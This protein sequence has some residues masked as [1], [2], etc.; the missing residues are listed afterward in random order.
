MERTFNIVGMTNTF[1]VKDS[2]NG[3]NCNFTITKMV[4]E[5]HT[6]YGH[7]DGKPI[8]IS[9]SEFEGECSSGWCIASWA[10]I[11]VNEVKEFPPFSYFP[12]KSPM[13]IT[14]D[15]ANDYIDCAAFEYS[16]HGDDEYYPSGYYSINFENFKQT[17][18]YSDKRVV[19]VFCGASGLGKTYLAG[20]LEEVDVYETDSNK[21]LPDVIYADVVVVGNK[22]KH[23]IEDVKNKLFENPCVRICRFE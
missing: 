14:F 15:S 10:D 18:R 5:R 7:S 17:P 6:L 13:E 16:S 4:G 9:L 11:I 2:W 1:Y 12:C 23:E 19:F 21:D 3:H 20:K 22:Y 8:S